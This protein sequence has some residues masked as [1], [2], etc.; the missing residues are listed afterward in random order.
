MSYQSLGRWLWNAGAFLFFA[1]VVVSALM[2]GCVE[3][4]AKSL[5]QTTPAG[6]LA[7]PDGKKMARLVVVDC[8]ATTNWSTSLTLEDVASGKTFDGLFTMEGKPDTV[9]LEWPNAHTLVVSGFEIKDLRTLRQ[10]HAS[11][12]NVVLAPR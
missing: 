1:G 8:G 11:G 2:V 3:L 9:K 7:S 6:L 4:T 10:D 5:C 12:V